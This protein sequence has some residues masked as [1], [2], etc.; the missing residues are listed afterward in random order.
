MQLPAKLPG[1]TAG[2]TVFT[3]INLF[4]DG[5]F[6]AA[7]SSPLSSPPWRAAVVIQIAIDVTPPPRA[8]KYARS[9]VRQ[10]GCSV[11]LWRYETPLRET[12]LLI[13]VTYHN[14]I[15]LRRYA[16]VFA[17]CSRFVKSQ[18]ARGNAEN[19]CHSVF[20]KSD[21]ASRK[22]HVSINSAYKRRFNRERKRVE[23]EGG[24]R[25]KRGKY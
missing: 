6:S 21:M 19:L 9:R 23:K 14:V 18:R 8:R 12:S 22:R 11:K 17:K 2:N 15:P 10:S 13:I 5:L 16:S 7:L 4:S 20:L 1:V 25:G 3:R 24:E